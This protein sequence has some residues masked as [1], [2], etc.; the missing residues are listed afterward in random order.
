MQDQWT[1][2]LRTRAAQTIRGLAIDATN[3]ARS[4]HPGAPMGLADVAVVLFGEVLR[5]DP[6]D[7]TW[8][9]RDR[10]VLSNG[11][12]SM[13]LYS[14]LHLCGY[15]L[16]IDELRRFRQLGSRT[17]GHPEVGV[18]PGV[19]TT[20]GPLGQGFA[21]AV[22]MA[23]AARMA[24]A[25]FDGE[26]FSPI[27]HSVFA[28]AGDGCLMEGISY[29]AAS[30]AGHLGLGE[31]VVLFDDN[32]ITIDGTT[33][34]STSED[35]EARFRAMNWSTTT[36]DGHDPAQIR[37]A[38][39]AGRAENDRPT[40]VCTKTHIGF[41][42]PNR[43]DTAKAHGEPLGDE[44]GRLTKEALGWAEEPFHVPDDVRAAFRAAGER[45]RAL[46]EAWEEQLERWS[47]EHPERADL[48][49]A[50]FS[51]SGP[52]LATLDRLAETLANATDATRS[53][54]GM[55]LNALAEADP[56]LVG[57]SADLAGSNKSTIKDSSFVTHDS[58]AGR[59]LHFGIREHSM[60]A[61]CNG[62][63]LSGGFLPFGAT[64][65]VFS[66]YMRPSI[67]LAAL[68]GVR[69]LFLFT[70]DSIGL[71]EDGPTH[72]PVEHLWSLRLIP[73]LS[74]WRPA[75]GIETAMAWGYAAHRGPEVPHALVFTRQK[76]PPL[77]RPEGF[78]RED[79]WRGAYLL[80]DVEEPV[81]TVLA[82]GSEVS[83]AV[84]AADLL[85]ER[86][87]PVR[88]VSVPC[89]ERFREQDP[90]Y[91]QAVLR[92][93]LPRITLEAGRTAPWAEL[94]GPAGLRL[95]ID[96]FGESAPYA[97]LYRHFGLDA[98]SVALRVEQYLDHGAHS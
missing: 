63:A 3:A 8:P 59:N 18:T 73:G 23:L 93:E 70:H 69:T 89:L 48:W 28:I 74:V 95:G 15:E 33:S 19:E 66:D 46:H 20:T 49:D 78:T 7:P 97:D 79:V 67:R 27:T 39:E 16:P 11:H 98:E 34:L 84:E 65:L 37:A 85:A 91:I 58:F 88:I 60:A 40:L 68:M 76:L 50:H 45:G 36:I 25:R 26:A 2:E 51:G 64:F 75:D 42:S 62:L 90:G 83:I 44:E 35:I 72:Q 10:F 81:A 14:A 38:L 96:R 77:E 47:D 41:G 82:T 30:L 53:M 94:T 13:L 80:R 86:G 55:V 5:F 71:G 31:L 6:D 61:I 54:S 24:K 52:D 56:R 12:A 29:E 9:D 32:G 17:P 1:P 4:G 22:G 92:P 57:G 21:N 43:Q 87:K